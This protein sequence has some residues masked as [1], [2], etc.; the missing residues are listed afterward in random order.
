MKNCY[1]SAL[2]GRESEVKRRSCWDVSTE[3]SCY[4]GLSV[5]NFSNLLLNSSSDDVSQPMKSAGRVTM[6]FTGWH[7]L[8]F[9][10]IN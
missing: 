2:E 6:T 7:A 1:S 8:T 5:R 3:C 9:S 4:D 10:P